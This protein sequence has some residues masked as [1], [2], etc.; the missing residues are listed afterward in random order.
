MSN[1]PR[2]PG[3]LFLAGVL[4]LAA[5]C[6][7]SEPPA[8]SASPEPPKPASTVV[9]AP[10]PAPAS[11]APAP[12][13]A[14]AL[15]AVSA[16][17][18]E[19]PA[20]V[21][22]RVQ[23]SEGVRYVYRFELEQHSTN[24]LAQAPRSTHEDLAMGLTYAVAGQGMAADN[25]RELKLD[26]L[27]YDV[28]IKVGGQTV[29]SFDSAPPGPA[30]PVPSACEPFKRVAGTSVGLILQANGGVQRLVGFD[31]WIKRVAG[32]G[33]EPAEQFLLQQFNEGF[34]RQLVDFGRGL[35]TNEVQVGE[36]WPYRAEMPAGALGKL[37]LDSKVTFAGWE[38]HDDRKLAVVEAHGTIQGEGKPEEPGPG[39]FW[40]EHG[41]VVS[42][43]WIDPDAGTLLESTSAQQMRLGGQ[44]AKPVRGQGRGGLFTSEIAQR[45]TLKLVESDTGKR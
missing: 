33:A 21:R 39:A 28:E 12:E 15:A 7:K 24:T 19:P 32:D 31:A 45:V 16:P 27:A 5:S 3:I 40:F 23:W 34:F 44:T 42:G 37:S 36:T 30:A 35:S 41:T 11:N 1:W 38:T 43:S 14:A 8:P 13:V 6:R 18:P 9:S 4:L 10:S 2:R 22:L 25:L 20:K 29:M 26:F 17:K